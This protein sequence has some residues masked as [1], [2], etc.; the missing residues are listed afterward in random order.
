MSF[1]WYPLYMV[2]IFDNWRSDI[3]VAF[4][5]ISG[6]R[7]QDLHHVHL[8]LHDRVQS[9]NSNW[10]PSPIIV[11]NAQ[12]ENNIFKYAQ[13]CLFLTQIFIFFYHETYVLKWETTNLLCEITIFSFCLPFQF[14]YVVWYLRSMVWSDAKKKSFVLM[15]CQQSLGKE[16]SEKNATAA[17]RTF[18]LQ[19]LGDIMY[20]RDCD[21]C[22]QWS[23]RLGPCATR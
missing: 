15:T 19:L 6:T 17:E 22:W 16:C 2:M 14:S 10:N 4:F 1:Q 18:N 21:R 12:V 7:E 13:L 8:T 11:N 3:H 9:I 23:C 20:R 5:I